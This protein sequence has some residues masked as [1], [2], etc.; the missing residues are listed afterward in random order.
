[1]EGD[2]IANLNLADKRANNILNV[3]QKNQ[4]QRINA[5]VETAISWDSFYATM[6]GHPKYL[7]LAKLSHPELIK[8]L[9]DDIVRSE[10]ERFL[11]AERKAEIALY[12]RVPANDQ[13]TPYLVIDQI[14]EYKRKLQAPLQ[15]N[16]SIQTYL[17]SINRYYTW[18][19]QLVVDQ[20][21]DTSVFAAV[22]MPEVF[23]TNLDLAQ[24]YLLFGYEMYHS[25]TNNSQWMNIREELMEGLALLPL[26]KPSPIFWYNLA[27]FKTRKIIEN[28]NFKLDPI[29]DVLDILQPL[30]NFYYDDSIARANIE[31]L[32][33]NL[34]MLLLNYVFP[35]NPEAFSK[36]AEVAL[37]QVG[38]Y[39]SNNDSVSVDLI[40]NMCRMA[41]SYNNIFQAQTLA[42]PYLDKPEVLQYIVPLSYQH[43]SSEGASIY[44]TN[45]V[46]LAQNISPET[47]CNMFMHECGIPFQ[48]F[49]HEK[50]RNTFCETCQGKNDYLEQLKKGQL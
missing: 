24:K 32:N 8:A 44:Y 39:Y 9:E 29:Q 4:Q 11:Q 16:L 17:D 27:Y 37:N 46:Q 41:V 43:P 19:H 45:L 25:F 10:L 23:K 33:F 49:D 26:K 18:A 40:I 15:N 13:N 21:L 48:A 50:L 7:N 5:S 47:W 1:M 14:N 28:K 35:E 30:R 12:I 22:T 6:L 31:S 3:W 36:N 20:K 38:L 42:I 2:S 34:N